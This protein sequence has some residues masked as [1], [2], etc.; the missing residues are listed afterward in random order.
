MNGSVIKGGRKK[1]KMNAQ[2]E[3]ERG[4]RTVRTSVFCGAAGVSTAYA[5]AFRKPL[6]VCQAHSCLLNL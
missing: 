6:I 2:E 5:E 4:G 3:D 1:G